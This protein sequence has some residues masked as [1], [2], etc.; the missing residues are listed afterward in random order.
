MDV[1]EMIGFARSIGVA[2]GVE[3]S[4]D[5]K[6]TVGN[7]LHCRNDHADVIR[8]RVSKSKPRNPALAEGI[9]DEAGGVEHAL[10]AQERAAT[11]FA[12]QDFASDRSPYFRGRERRR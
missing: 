3:G 5:G 9:A 4:G 1:E 7:A 10:G 12:G 2:A 8:L 6:Q 11:K